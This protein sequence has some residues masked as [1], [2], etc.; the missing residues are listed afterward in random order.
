LK[1]NGAAT[2]CKADLPGSFASTARIRDQAGVARVLLASAGSRV[3]RPC[4]GRADWEYFKS[5]GRTLSARRPRVI[6]AEKLEHTSSVFT[7][8]ITAPTLRLHGAGTHDRAGEKLLTLGV[9]A[10]EHGMF[11]TAL[12]CCRGQREKI[13][14]LETAEMC[15]TIDFGPAC[16]GYYCTPFQGY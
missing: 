11:A 10:F 6:P 7:R 15:G 1:R 3:D 4:D 2:A 13:E 14:M 5:R 12:W 8:P 16:T 9:C